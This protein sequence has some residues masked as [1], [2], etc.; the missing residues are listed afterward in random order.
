MADRK[1]NPRNSEST[2]FRQLTRLFSGPIVN[3]R[4]QAPRKERRRHLDKYRFKSA[5]GQQ[6]KKSEYNPYNSIEAN[7]MSNQNRADRYVD[8]DQMEY[9]PE[10]ASSMDIYADEMTTS[11]EIS[12]LLKIYCPNEEIKLVL[13]TLYHKVLNIEFNLFGWCR[14]MCKFGDFFLYL[15]IDDEEGIKHAIGLP[16]HEIERLEGEDKTNPNYVQ[17]QWNSGGMTLEN[18]Q[19]A[20]FRILGNDKYAPYGTSVLEPARRIWRQLTLMEDA[21]MAYRIVR[22]PERRVFYIDV[23]SIP[24]GDVEQY[25][26]KVMTQMKRNQ[27]VD[28]DTGRV[29]LRY[30]PMS[31]EEDYFIPVRG[32]TN[33][34]VETLAGGSY[35]GDIDDI[36]YLRDK[37]FS[38]LKVP[39]SYLSRGEGADEDK[40]TLAQKDIRFARTIQ[41]LQRSVV[42]ELEKIGIV[43]LFALGY[44][45]KDLT[46]FKLG[47][48]NPSKLAQL[49]ELEHWRTR[50]EIAS[51]ATEGYFSR[52][53]IA[54]NLFDISE[55]EIVRMQREMFFDR[56][57]DASLEKVAEE[58]A[59]S[60]MGGAGGLG[61]LGGDDELGAEDL[62]GDDTP[63]TPGAPGE[64]AGPGAEDDSMLLASPDS[65]A[66]TPPGPGKRDIKR[67][68][69]RNARGQKLST[70]KNSNDKWYMA[71]KD[72]PGISD[73]RD[74]G[75][76]RRHLRGLTNMEIAKPVKRNIKGHN[77]LLGLAKGITENVDTNYYDEEENKLFE[78]NVE[79]KKLIEELERKEI[80]ERPEDETSTQ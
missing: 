78:V 41:R 71:A 20:H 15:D 47:L 60:A 49:Q 67:K 62:L 66:D 10:I 5:S 26:Q 50:F 12:P 24:P 21:V 40:T 29:D 11:T 55:E 68:V 69:K 34:R 53:W 33:S 27:I 43:H 22:S 65:P 72:N 79:M 46:T 39:A 75:A 14:T 57:L 56:K 59:A 38:A 64:E 4:R 13:D 6:F 30:N 31:V 36:K 3:Y 1:R 42:S 37:L 52:R 18:W 28:A 58:T 7:Y 61:D 25:I 74:V 16:P 19:M 45:G 32:D 76:Y 77:E 17:F 70:S 63:G 23:G 51:G 44:R 48:N 9:T 2:L 8:F 73:N 80:L 35:T 54:E